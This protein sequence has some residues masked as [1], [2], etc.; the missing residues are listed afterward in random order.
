MDA[1]QLIRVAA[2]IIADGDRYLMTRRP[3]GKHMAGY[4]EFP[5][6][7][8]E[9]GE[10][11]AQALARELEEELG[12]EVEVRGSVD[13]LRHRYGDRSVELHFLEAAI[14]S[15]RP[16][17]LEVDDLGW[18]TP[19]EMPGLPVLEA[20]LPLVDKLDGRQAVRDTE[21]KAT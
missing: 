5:G 17:A 16:R 14:R 19:A 11:P 4:W 21:G 10:S 6:G 9:P 12:I 15:G 2:A 8:I 3:A 13:V 20:D 1:E 18:F 7:K